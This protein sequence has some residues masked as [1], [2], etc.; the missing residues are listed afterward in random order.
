N[1]LIHADG[2]ACLADFGLSVLYS[3]VVSISQA[4]WT[5]SFHG[6]VRWLAPERLGQS[7]NDMPVRPRKH[8]DVYSFG[9]IM[10]LVLTNR[11]PSHYLTNEAAV[12]R[13]IDT[14]KKPDRSRYSALSG[15]YWDFMQECW[16]T[17]IHDRPSTDKVAQVISDEFNSLSSSTN[18][19]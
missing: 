10:L 13:C 17:A 12:I 4:S 16:S 15:K 11:S 19:F 6:N 14:G 18:N 8:S 3:G 7:D 9:G 5:S 2:T 1:V